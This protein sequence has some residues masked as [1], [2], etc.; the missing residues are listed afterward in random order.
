MNSSYK[1]N[2]L[3]TKFN[4]M[5]S[6]EDYKPDSFLYIVARHNVYLII[7]PPHKPVINNIINH[8]FHF[9]RILSF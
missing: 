4:D 6:N 8:Q 2:F 3:I 1:Y 9:V 5:N 7:V